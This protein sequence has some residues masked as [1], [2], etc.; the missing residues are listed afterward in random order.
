MWSPVHELNDRL[1]VVDVG[2]MPRV[3]GVWFA[4][5][6][7]L[8]PDWHRL[9]LASTSPPVEGMMALTATPASG[10]VIRFTRHPAMRDAESEA[11]LYTR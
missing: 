2:M 4:S 1:S 6:G 3:Q 5:H 9:G 11:L 7:D 10:V 8:V